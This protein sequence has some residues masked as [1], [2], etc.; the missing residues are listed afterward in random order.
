[1][2]GSQ[3]RVLACVFAM[4]LQL[5]MTLG[6]EPDGNLY[7]DYAANTTTTTEPTSTSAPPVAAPMHIWK[8]VTSAGID[9]TYGSCGSTQTQTA[10][11]DASKVDERIYIAAQLRGAF[12][13]IFLF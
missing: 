13:S 3:R 2:C 6:C 4:L 1:M 8:Q 12:P 11:C 9:V 10:V 7:P 5:E